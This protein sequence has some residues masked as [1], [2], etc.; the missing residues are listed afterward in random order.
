MTGATDNRADGGDLVALE[1]LSGNDDEFVDRAAVS[2]L[3]ALI[4]AIC[5]GHT[6]M[7][8]Y[9]RPLKVAELAGTVAFDAYA[10]ARAMLSERS[11]GRAGE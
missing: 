11:K 1:R 8:G 10:I 6:G 7:E 4:S 5:A 2:A 9:R 3:P